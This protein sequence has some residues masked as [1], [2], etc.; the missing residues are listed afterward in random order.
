MSGWTSWS[1]RPTAAFDPVWYRRII[2]SRTLIAAAACLLTLVLAAPGLAR[3]ETT[4]A[5]AIVT[6]RVTVTDDGVT[7]KPRR[8][9]RGSTAI[10]LLANHATRPHE[11]VIGD[12]ERGVGKK[13]GFTVKLGP[14]GQERIVMFLDYRGLLP[15]GTVGKKTA[16][17]KGVFRIT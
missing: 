17:H 16:A 9:L 5:P 10:F 6:I 3:R 15:Y 14:N 8:A 7:M 11:F 12:I 13:I 4:N 1:I 2:G